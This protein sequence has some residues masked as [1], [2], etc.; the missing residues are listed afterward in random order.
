MPAADDP[1]A[2]HVGEIVRGLNRLEGQV[3]GLSRQ[4][5]DYPKWHDITRIEAN[6]IARISGAEDVAKATRAKVDEDAKA[7][8]GRTYGA[9]VTGSGGLIAALLVWAL[10]GR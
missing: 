3:A 10:T 1:E 5:G 8:K 9:L 6:L 2:V 7:A 4:I